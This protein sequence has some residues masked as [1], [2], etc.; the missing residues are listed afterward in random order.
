MMRDI[1]ARFKYTERADP[2]AP[3]KRA[4]ASPSDE[5]PQM[6]TGATPAA[7]SPIAAMS[8]SPLPASPTTGACPSR[9]LI[10]RCLRSYYRDVENRTATWRDVSER[11]QS[12]LAPYSVLKLGGFSLGNIA[13]K[14]IG[15]VLAHCSNLRTV[16]LGFNR[17]SDK[18]AALLAK[19]LEHNASLESLYLSGND[20]GPAGA[21]ALAT[22]LTKNSTLRSL[23]LSGNN[24]GEDGAA[25]LADGLKANTGLRSLY[26]GTNGI[27]SNGMARLADAL[28]VNK[29]LEELTL[30]QNRIGSDGLR[31]LAAAFAS[32]ETVLTTLE[33]GKNGVDADGALA[34]AK[35][36]CSARNSLQNLYM[37]NN[38]MGD[39]GA[40]A[41]GALVAKNAVL[42]VLDV[43]YSQ[44]SL[45]GLRDLSMGL[46]YSTSLLCLLLDGHDWASTQF[47]K[48]T[49]GL[50]GASLSSKGASN[51]AAS[52]IVGAINANPRS[53]LVKLT[54]VDLSLV[55]PV[56]GD[57]AMD[58]TTSDD[59]AASGATRRYSDALTRNERVL[60]LLQ[61]ARRTTTSNKRKVPD[62]DE[63][64]RASSPSGASSSGAVDDT[65]EPT[66]PKYQRLDANGPVKSSSSSGSIG[67]S[68]GSSDSASVPSAAAATGSAVVPPPPAFTARR[69]PRVGLPSRGSLVQLPT[70]AA[71]SGSASVPAPR[72]ALKSPRYESTMDVHV[73]KVV[74]EIATLPF[75]ADEYTNLQAYYLGGCHGPK[76]PGAA[77]P[78]ASTALADD[79]TVVREPS[80]CPACR[81]SRLAKF[82]RVMALKARLEAR[83]EATPA[84]LLVLLR[85]LHYLIGVFQHVDGADERID[86]LL[87]SVHD[88]TLLASTAAVPRHPG[89]PRSPA[90]AFTHAPTDG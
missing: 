32:G 8:S 15:H 70:A 76:D 77:A 2:S 41:F 3:T 21:K 59:A 60:K 5:Q 12:D 38:P 50:T 63:S 71:A 75:N 88:P 44:M 57:S 43:S 28:R 82:R 61:D 69:P 66:L 13:P 4:G 25:A 26:V 40:S 67:S 84:A 74:A 23:H 1:S 30:G 39:V 68:S 64:P 47:M 34:L 24:I 54:G 29:V 90:P 10:Q 45:L 83:K 42:R 36:L 7:A 6:P 46:A 33:I 56:A 17:I 58:A 72:L 51:Y 73:R 65:P 79:N 35:A 62:E 49:N 53:V 31:H 52:C 18:G 22:A 89:P 11:M 14:L 27:G 19:A 81:N 48:K 55:A 85:Q 37:D 20:I 80:L 16:D 87:V 9:E 86:A 78:D